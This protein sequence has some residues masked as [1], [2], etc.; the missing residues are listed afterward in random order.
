MHE[1]RWTAKASC[2]SEAIARLE[3]EVF[4]ETATARRTD[5]IQLPRA[6]SACKGDVLMV[7]AGPRAG[8]NGCSP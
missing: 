4:K 5:N 7:R 8:A 3:R 2:A 6:R 1:Y